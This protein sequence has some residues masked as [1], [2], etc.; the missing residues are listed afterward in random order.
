MKPL[1]LVLYLEEEAH[2]ALNTLL[3]E[4]G[5]SHRP[6]ISRNLGLCSSLTMLRMKNILCYIVTNM[7]LFVNLYFQI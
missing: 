4:K 2:I 6:K 1:S 3:I 7:T 5:R